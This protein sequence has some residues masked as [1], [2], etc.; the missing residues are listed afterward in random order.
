MKALAVF[1]ISLLAF[2]TV[3]FST[4]IVTQ[5]RPLLPIM[6][7][8]K[9]FLMKNTY[10]SPEA[11]REIPSPPPP[12][13]VAPPIHP[14]AAIKFMPDLLQLS[15]EFPSNQKLFTAPTVKD[16]RPFG[17]I[18][19]SSGNGNRFVKKNPMDVEKRGATPSPPPPPRHS[20]PVGPVL[21]HKSPPNPNPPDELHQFAFA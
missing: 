2:Q 12:P 4:T 9:N 17:L 10:Y 7:N 15:G 21:K 20:P 19:D 13:E 16:A 5:A 6:E 18:L 3:L 8:P 1:L 14:H 11:F